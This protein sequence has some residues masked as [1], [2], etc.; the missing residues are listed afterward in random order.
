MGGVGGVR[1][2]RRDSRKAFRGDQEVT[3]D[4]SLA[5]NR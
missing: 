1:R 2:K 4:R 5:G 3:V